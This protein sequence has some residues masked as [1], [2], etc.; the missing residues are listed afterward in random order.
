[1]AMSRD[2]VFE[3]VKDVLVDALGVDDDEVSEGATLT[4][5]LG[6]ES[7]DFLDIVFR[8]ERT[9]SIKIPRGELFPDDIMNNPEYVENGRMTEKGMTTL[10]NAMPHADFTDFEKDPDVAKMTDLFTVKTI[11]NYV[12]AKLAA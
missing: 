10:K 3:K 2:E 5:D 6:A 12:T 7:I 11:V 9:F 4:G 8:L 1:M